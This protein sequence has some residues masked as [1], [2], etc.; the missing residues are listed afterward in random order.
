MSVLPLNL[1][2]ANQIWL[3]EKESDSDAFLGAAFL[4]TA[5]VRGTI[6]R[7]V[8]AVEFWQLWQLRLNLEQNRERS[9]WDRKIYETSAAALDEDSDALIGVKRLKM[10]NPFQRADPCQKA[11]FELLLESRSFIR[12]VITQTPDLRAET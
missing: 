3:F 7:H 8:G 11:M 12:R 9:C 5:N 6:A 2:G 1:F 4:T 10:V